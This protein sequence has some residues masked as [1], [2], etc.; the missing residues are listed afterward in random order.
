MTDVTNPTL[1]RKSSY[2][3]GG[4]GNCVEVGFGVTI[5]VRD[6]KDRTGGTLEFD[7]S[8]WTTFVSAVKNGWIGR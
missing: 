8:T 6:T 5:G 2:S 3:A 1:W 7:R 4:N